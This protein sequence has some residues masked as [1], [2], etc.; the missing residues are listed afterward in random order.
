MDFV[1]PDDQQVV[2][3]ALD[4]F[5]SGALESSAYYRH[6]SADGGWLWVE[7]RARLLANAESG[8]AASYVVVLRDATQIK[9]EERKLNDALDRVERLAATDDLTGLANRRRL[10]DVADLEWQ[11]NAREHT[12]LSILLLDADRFKLFNDRYGHVAGDHCLREIAFQID[13]IAQR[14]GDLGARYGGEEFMLLLPNTSHEGALELGERLCKCVREQG[15]LHEGNVEGV[16][17][18]SVG[19]ATARPG[20]SASAFAS[21]NALIAGADAALYQAKNEGR[22]RVCSA[23]ANATQVGPAA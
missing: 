4:A 1:H 20:D 3:S 14:P 21:L 6:R 17:T 12:Q 7:G 5:Q 16:V 22:N 2:K 13:A 18:V 23:M 9:E 15:I 10:R 11:R 8:D 19:V